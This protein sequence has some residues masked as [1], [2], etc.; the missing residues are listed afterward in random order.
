MSE[1]IWRNRSRL[2]APFGALGLSLSRFRSFAS[3]KLL[4]S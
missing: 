1:V 3:A 2:R 4:I